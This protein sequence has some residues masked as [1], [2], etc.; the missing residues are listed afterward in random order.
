MWHWLAMGAVALY[1]G[2]SASRRAKQ[3][4]AEEAWHQALRR[5]LGLMLVDLDAKSELGDVVPHADRLTRTAIFCFYEKAGVE[6]FPGLMRFLT[7]M[8]VPERIAIERAVVTRL[9]ATMPID[10]DPIFADDMIRRALTGAGQ[11]A[12]AAARRSK[13]I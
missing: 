11:D 13:H 7:K 12:M 10:S 1:A 8:T 9:Q 4:I 6:D 2:A 5:R 3:R